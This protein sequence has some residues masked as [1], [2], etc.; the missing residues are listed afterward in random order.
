MLGKIVLIQLTENIKENI[1]SDL[2]NKL[3]ENML[4]T[5]KSP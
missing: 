4:L 3:Y 5:W 1:L 2:M